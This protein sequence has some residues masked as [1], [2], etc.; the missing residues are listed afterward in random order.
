MRKN[1]G[2]TTSSTSNSHNSQYGF[3]DFLNKPVEIYVF[4]DPLCPECW[5]LEPFLKKLKIEYGRYFKLRPIVSGKLSSL[6]ID[7]MKNPKDLADVWEKTASR[8][9]MSCDGDLWFENPVSS[10]WLPTIAIKAAEL[11]GGKPGALFLRK[12]QEHL[13]VSK[14]NISEEDVLLTC[15][16]EAKLDV[17]EFHKDLYGDSAKKALQCDLRLTQEMEVDEI[18]TI[19]LFNQTEEQEGIKISGLYPYNVYVKMLHEVLGQTPRP[20]AKPSL[21]EFVRYFKF[22]ATK[23]ISVVF[24][25]SNE[26]TEKEMK[27]LLFR[28]TVEKMPAK[29]DTFWRYVGE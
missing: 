3:F 21:E 26:R 23:E 27:K 29:Y 8:T 18:P 5:S 13:F 24:D 16:R 7:K 19:V 2:H 14:E 10:P 20:A 1:T 11:Q 6:N 9:G 4:V 12:I 22:V 15:A 25:W 17:E 28:Q